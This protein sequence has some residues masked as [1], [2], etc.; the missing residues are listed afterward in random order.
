MAGAEQ[1]LQQ[2]VTVPCAGGPES[3]TLPPAVDQEFLSVSAGAC[4]SA[5]SGGPVIVGHFVDENYD[6][7]CPDP[8]SDCESMIDDET[9]MRNVTSVGSADDY[10]LSTI[11]QR[12]SLDCGCDSCCCR[13]AADDWKVVPSIDPF[14]EDLPVVAVEPT[15]W[16]RRSSG[17]R[18]QQQSL[19][20][21]P[22]RW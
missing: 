19:S 6:A 8:G 15:L 10:C 22:V 1:A 13:S 2:M 20:A 9:T 5:P 16:P 18:L 3:A 21:T 11:D 4:C 17:E 12:L 14:P 7:D